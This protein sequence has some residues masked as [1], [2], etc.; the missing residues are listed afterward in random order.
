MSEKLEGKDSAVI[1]QVKNS[2]LVSISHS[3][4]FA[5]ELQ[6]KQ[7]SVSLYKCIKMP[8]IYTHLKIKILQ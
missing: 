4:M 7:T 1:W 6:T 5:L 3:Q 2:W 8:K